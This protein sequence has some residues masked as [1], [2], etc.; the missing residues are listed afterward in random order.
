MEFDDHSGA[1]KPPQRLLH[2]R[3]RAGSAPPGV[4]LQQVEPLPVAGE[5]VDGRE[6]SLHRRDV[7]RVCPR[8]QRSGGRIP[9][10]GIEIDL[11]LDAV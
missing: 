1:G 8:R 2:P 7:V 3:Q 11:G 10:V 5:L 6:R 4:D 9:V